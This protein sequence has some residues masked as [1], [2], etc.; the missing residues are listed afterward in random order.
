[1]KS[2][3]MDWDTLMSDWQQSQHSL[4]I[5]QLEEIETSPEKRIAF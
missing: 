1:L 2:V 4:E 3:K 5:E